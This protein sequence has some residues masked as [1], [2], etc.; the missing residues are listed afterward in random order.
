MPAGRLREGAWVSPHQLQVLVVMVMVTAT[1]GN[2][3]ELLLDRWNFYWL[4]ENCVVNHHQ[5]QSEWSP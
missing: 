4:A 3:C 1:V 5:S 2:D